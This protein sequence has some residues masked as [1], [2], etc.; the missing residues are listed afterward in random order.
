MRIEADG[1]YGASAGG[2]RLM[3]T[4]K[5]LVGPRGD[6]V[7]GDS[8]GGGSG[9]GVCGIHDRRVVCGVVGVYAAGD[10][11]LELN[12]GGD[13]GSCGRCC[14]CAVIVVVIGGVAGASIGGVVPAVFGEC[15]RE[16][17]TLCGNT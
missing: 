14:C 1:E 13:A 11:R 4:S 8:T 9:G 12:D 6:S 15:C 10:W 16:A 7:D 2:T 3:L 17:I 5:A